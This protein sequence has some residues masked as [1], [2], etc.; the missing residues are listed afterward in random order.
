MRRRR[1]TQDEK[2]REVR[3]RLVAAGILVGAWLVV[4]G[5]FSVLTK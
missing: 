1:M 5:L 2:R 3:G 4:F